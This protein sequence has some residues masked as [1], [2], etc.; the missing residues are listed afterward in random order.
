MKKITSL[1]PLM[2]ILGACQ[3]AGDPASKQQREAV[4]TVTL[5]ATPEAASPLV[6]AKA[7]I[8]DVITAEAQVE[9]AAPK[10]SETPASNTPALT[11]RAEVTVPITT[12]TPTPSIQ[13]GILPAGA[14]R[15]VAQRLCSSCHS[16]VLVTQTGHTEEEW[17]SIILRMENNGMMASPEDIDTV[18]TYL[19][20]ALPPR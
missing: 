2:F 6:D 3:A 1:I 18:I 13:P 19:G 9:T 8:A 20:K 15:N 7:P 12:P 10:S 11:Q 16:L 17:D 5:S 14:G 4:E